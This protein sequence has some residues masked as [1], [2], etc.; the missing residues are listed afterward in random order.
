VLEGAFW[1]A[2]VLLR[3]L[4]DRGR[5]AQA[6]AEFQN[7]FAMARFAAQA[8]LVRLDFAEVAADLDVPDLPPAKLAA[9]VRDAY[10][11][12]DMPVPATVEERVR[13]LESRGSRR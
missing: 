9:M 7:A 11:E 5:V 10:L 1:G 3:D 13:A 6:K 12:L 8:P 2:T 4:L